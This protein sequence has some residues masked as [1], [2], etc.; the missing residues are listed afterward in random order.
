MLDKSHSLVMCKGVSVTKCS[1]KK[2]ILNS[3]R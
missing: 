1:E 3:A 2:V